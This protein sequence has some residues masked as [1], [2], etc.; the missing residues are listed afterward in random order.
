MF[1]VYHD[2]LF[3]VAEDKNHPPFN[4]ENL[5]TFAAELGL[6]PQS[7]N[8]C[9]DADKYSPAVEVDTQAAQ[10][11]GFQGT[12]AFLINGRPVMGAQPFEVFQ[13]YIEEELSK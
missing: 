3:A 7:F 4:K 11:L 1:W 5:K 13:Q 8:E 6:D 9:L 12:P 2:K 10:F